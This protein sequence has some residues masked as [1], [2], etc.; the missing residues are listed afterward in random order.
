VLKEETEAD[1]HCYVEYVEEEMIGENPDDPGEQEL[2]DDEAKEE[3][4][5]EFEYVPAKR[6]RLE[7]I[8]ECTTY[9]CQL[10]SKTFGKNHVK[11]SSIVIITNFSLQIERNTIVDTSSELIWRLR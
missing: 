6:Q 4:E 11:T 8:E 9:S 2:D 1:E 7:T 3:E 10:C 5:E